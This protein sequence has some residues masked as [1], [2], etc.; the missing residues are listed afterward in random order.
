MIHMMDG[1]DLSTFDDDDSELLQIAMENYIETFISDKKNARQMRNI[2]KKSIP[3]GEKYAIMA[4]V[5]PEHMQQ[6]VKQIMPWKINTKAILWV[7]VPLT[8][9]GKILGNYL[10]KY[11]V[12]KQLL[13][14]IRLYY[15]DEKNPDYRDH[16]KFCK[17]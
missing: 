13:L 11:D 8:Q 12:E 6:N 2:A 16:V 15:G 3:K 14:Y 17:I 4:E 10:D 1:I 7:A 9:F 5:A